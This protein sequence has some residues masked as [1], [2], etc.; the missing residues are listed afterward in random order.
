MPNPSKAIIEQIGG[1][2]AVKELVE[3]FYDIIETHPAG[4]DILKLHQDG[5]GLRHARLEQFD[6][7]C[8][9]LGGNRYYFEKHKHMNVKQIHA[10]VE[11]NQEASD[12]WLSCMDMAMEK[13]GISH[14]LAE[15]MRHTFKNVAKILVNQ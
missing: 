10:H 4:K 2:T 13:C 6:F 8:G 9:F 1:E 3:T 7:M 11:I 15:K 14:E 12:N 5:H